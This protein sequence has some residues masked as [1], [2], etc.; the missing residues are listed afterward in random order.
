MITVRKDILSDLF[1]AIDKFVIEVFPYV[2]M[3]EKI[4]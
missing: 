4:I 1:A 2:D 3:V